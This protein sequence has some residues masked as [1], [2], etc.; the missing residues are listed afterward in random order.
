MLFSNQGACMLR[1]FVGLGFGVVL[2]ILGLGL[3]GVGH[4]SYVP[5]IF[6]NPLI[7]LPLPAFFIT[8]GS[9][10]WALY[11]VLVPRISAKRIRIVTICV[12]YCTHLGI[13]AL[14]ANQDS[15][16]R[17][18]ISE[19]P[20]AI[21]VFAALFLLMMCMLLY[22]STRAVGKQRSRGGTS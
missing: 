3:G 7:L 6:L 13:G 16:F 4:G 19:H 12:I 18:S 11:F 15:A 22:F 8:I 21:V 5:M 17:R 10:L 9:V 20:T 14:Y 2:T 1:F